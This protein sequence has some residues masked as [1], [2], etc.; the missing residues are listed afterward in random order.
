VTAQSV[1]D[2]DQANAPAT[3]D[4]AVVAFL[5]REARLAD[6]ARYSEWESLWDSDATYWVP[7]REDADPE[8]DLSYIYDNRRRIA[9]R[10]A[11]LNTGSRHSQTPPSKMR[12][13]IS[14]IELLSSDERSVTVGAN[15]VLFEYRTDMVIWAGRYLYRV[16]TDSRP[17]RLLEKTVHL[18]NAHDSVPTMSFLI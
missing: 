14:N 12:R 4:P 11:Q 9:S 1:L 18:V 13:L 17:L 16:R 10:I 2:A 8:T 7:M 15:F 6:E 5:Y 3:I